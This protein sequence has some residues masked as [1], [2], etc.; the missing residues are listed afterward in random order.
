MT[1]LDEVLKSVYTEALKPV[2]VW[3]I[4][5]NNGQQLTTMDN[6]EQQWTIMDNN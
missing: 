6:N 3:T 5:D 2:A 1:S 4:M